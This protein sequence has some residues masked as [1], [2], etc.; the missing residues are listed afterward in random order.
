MRAVLEEKVANDPPSP[1]EFAPDIDPG[2]EHLIL[3]GVARLP[4]DRYQTAADMLA[5]LV[6]IKHTTPVHC[7]D[8]LSRRS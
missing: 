7:V 5:G 6:R 4:S 8:R 3:R 1:R 2:L